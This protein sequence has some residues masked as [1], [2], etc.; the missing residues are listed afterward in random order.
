MVLKKPSLSKLYWGETSEYLTSG[1]GEDALTTDGDGIITFPRL[2]K[3]KL[4]R[5]WWPSI[6]EQ[7]KNFGCTILYEVD[8]HT[9]SCHPLLHEQLFDRIV[10]NF[11]HAGFHYREYDSFQIE[12]HRNLVKGFLR[13]ARDDM[14]GKNR[15]AHVTH[16]TAHPFDRWEIE[17]LAEDVG[18]YLIEMSPFS[19][20]DYLGCCN[21]RGDGIRVDDSFPVG[22]CST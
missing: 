15:E 16:K 5:P 18:W 12:F 4:Y 20:W 19:S 7:L 11:P 10:F 22:A 9:M 8:A 3:L 13:S 2:R 17:K 6:P 14:L 1:E 21:K